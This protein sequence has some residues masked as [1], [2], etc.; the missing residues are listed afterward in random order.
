MPKD[1]KTWSTEEAAIKS[2]ISRSTIM[3]W[4]SKGLITP[5]VNVPMNGITLHRWTAA[6][7]ER[8]KTVVETNYGTGRTGR[9]PKKGSK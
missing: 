1:D 9:P 2:G 8:L 3:R 5:S 7:V 6:D 4:M